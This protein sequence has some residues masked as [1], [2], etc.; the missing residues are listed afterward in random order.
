MP[1]RQ[2]KC[3]HR[4]LIAPTTGDGAAKSRILRFQYCRISGDGHLCPR[5]AGDGIYF[6]FLIVVGSIATNL[7]HCINIPLVN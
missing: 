1:A 7:I 6:F 2:E 5:S 4:S 3:L